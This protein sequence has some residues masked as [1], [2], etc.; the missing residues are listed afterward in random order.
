MLH[1]NFQVIMFT[2]DVEASLFQFTV[3]G[4]ILFSPIAQDVVDNT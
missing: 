4:N 1:N 3:F 2:V